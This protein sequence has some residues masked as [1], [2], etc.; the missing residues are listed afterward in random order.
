M[1]RNPMHPINPLVGH[2]TILEAARMAGIAVGTIKGWIKAGRLPAAAVREF[3]EGLW[4][5]KVELRKA[6][7]KRRWHRPRRRDPGALSPN[8]AAEVL[9]ITGEAVKQWIYQG[10]LKATKLANGY[11]RIKHDDLTKFLEERQTVVP[12]LT[13][14]GS[15]QGMQSILDKVAKDLNFAFTT[16]TD[17]AAAQKQIKTQAPNLL[18]L[19]L[20]SFQEGWKLIRRVRGSVRYGS[21]KILLL[22]QK[23]LSEKE[24]S[25]AVRLGVSGCLEGTEALAAEVRRL[26]GF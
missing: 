3:E 7:R 22:S 26:V 12:L 9:G 19:D 24:T 5:N 18:V 23:G 10:L 21:P 16:V 1:A 15:N 11:W 8:E 4:I 17:I 14:A 6:I 25:E 2:V 20:D 13:F